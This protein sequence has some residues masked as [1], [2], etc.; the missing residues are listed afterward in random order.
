MSKTN[1]PTKIT[2]TMQGDYLIPDLTL[3]E[4]TEVELGTYARMRRKFLQEEH[5]VLY[6]NLLTSCKLNEH[7]MEVQKRATELQET[8]TKQMAA[9]EGI[10]EQLKAEDMMSWVRKMNNLQNR[11][12]EIVLSEVIYV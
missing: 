6:G 3:P 2:Y 5:P 11:I 4:Q 8:L 12:Q 9:T 7:L 10:T 1:E